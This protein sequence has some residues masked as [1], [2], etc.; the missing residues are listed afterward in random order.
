MEKWSP[1]IWTHW[2]NVPPPIWSLYSG[3]PQPV[4]LKNRIF[5]GPIVQGDQVG[6][7][8]FFHGDQIFWH[9]LSIGIELVEDHFSRGINQL[10]TNFGG[11]NIRGSYA[12]RTICVTANILGFVFVPLPPQHRIK[13]YNQ[14]LLL[15]LITTLV[16]SQIV[17]GL[18][19][20]SFLQ[21]QIQVSFSLFIQGVQR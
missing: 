2:T 5:N 4:L 6:W 11:P 8:P 20:P 14:D 21:H 3:S 19:L 7:G 9:H 18:E 12:F 16:A 17:A 10:R 1:Q 15:S 13:N